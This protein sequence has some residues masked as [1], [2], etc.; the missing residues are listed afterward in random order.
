MT[1]ISF[2]RTEGSVLTGSFSRGGG[3]LVAIRNTLSCSLINPSRADLEQVFVRVRFRTGHVIVGALYL[4]PALQP[5]LYDNHVGCVTEIFP[6]YSDDGFCIF[7]DYNL[8]HADWSNVPGPMC[9]KKP[10]ILTFYWKVIIFV[11]L[12][13]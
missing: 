6:N 4:P 13:R 11:L 1:L 3:V 5:L 12:L 9:C 8:P 2:G 7:G 10:G